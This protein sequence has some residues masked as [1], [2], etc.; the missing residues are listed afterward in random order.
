MKVEKINK[1]V[2]PS[3][4]KSFTKAK[5]GFKRKK[6]WPGRKESRPKTTRSIPEE[7]EI[8]WGCLVDGVCI[9]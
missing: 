8:I 2:W 3:P 5:N 1:R 9:F 7:T 4:K 6:I